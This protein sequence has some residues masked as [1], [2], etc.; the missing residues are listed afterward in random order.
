MKMLED[1]EERHKDKINQLELELEN[2]EAFSQVEI[3]EIQSKSE[4]ALAQLKNFYELEKERLE[5][6]IQE[7]KDR[8]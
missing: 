7:E 3:N 6:R 8:A 2:K 1:A 5:R 4:E